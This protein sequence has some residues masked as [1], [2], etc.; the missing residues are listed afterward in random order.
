MVHFFLFSIGTTSN[1]VQNLTIKAYMVC[2]GLKPRTARLYAQTNPL[3]FGGPLL[4][5][6]NDQIGDLPR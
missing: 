4:I 5:G 3:S 6:S 1:I 2:L